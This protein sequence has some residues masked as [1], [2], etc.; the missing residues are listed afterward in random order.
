MAMLSTAKGQVKDQ[1]EEARLFVQK[2][3]DW[4]GALD[5]QMMPGGKTPSPYH[6]TL[7]HKPPYLDTKLIN[8]LLGDDKAQADNPGEI[9]GLDSDPFTNAQDTRSGYQTGIVT[10]KGIYYFVDVHDIKSG[11]SKKEILA[12]DLVTTAEVTNINGHWVFVNFIYPKADGGG[13]L[14]D[15]L[16]GMKKDRAKWGKKE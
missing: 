10:Q 16:A 9:V 3:Y 1:K 11:H 13:N 7:I 5:A 6:L 8:A 12:A 14:L 15:L 4:Y 2:F